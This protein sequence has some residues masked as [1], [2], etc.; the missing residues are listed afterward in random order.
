M[1]VRWVSGN[2]EAGATCSRIPA[3]VDL[4]LSRSQRSGL[5]QRSC[6]VDP[7]AESPVAAA[8]SHAAGDAQGLDTGGV[9]S[10]SDGS[11]TYMVVVGDA[12]F[13]N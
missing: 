12:L 1:I 6:A 9:R 11:R 7:A 4:R 5:P 8:G 3:E 10:L 13:P 2:R